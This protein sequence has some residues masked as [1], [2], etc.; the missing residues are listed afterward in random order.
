M[1]V[2]LYGMPCSGKTHLSGMLKGLP[3]QVHVENTDL[4][5]VQELT[6]N[7]ALVEYTK[8]SRFLV[9]P[10]EYARVVRG[11]TKPHTCISSAIH[12]PEFHEVE[13][14]FV[15]QL[16]R[17]IQDYSAEKMVFEGYAIGI[18]LDKIMAKAS[19]LDLL[20]ARVNNRVLEAQGD[21]I[22]ITPEN[23]PRIAKLLFSGIA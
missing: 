18:L 2:L 11:V 20:A 9:E 10:S 23:L 6:V 19:H 13:D 7:R 15:E 14:I 16:F 4:Y 12:S 22:P 1:V 3:D 5:F 21:A 8:H 17:N